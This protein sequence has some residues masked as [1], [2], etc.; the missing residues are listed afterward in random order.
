MNKKNLIGTWITIPDT[1]IAEILCSSNLDWITI[2]REHSS[3]SYEQ[4]EN[5]IRIA[6]LNKMK[7]YVRIS[8]INSSEI[9]K[10]LDSGADGIIIPN[11]KTEDQIEKIVNYSYYPPIGIR[12]VGLTR[13]NMFGEKF[14]QYYNN[15]S[16]KIKLIV[17]IEHYKAVDNI[18]K[19]LSN[20]YVDG[21]FIGPYDLSAS[22]GVPGKFKSKKYLKYENKIKTYMKNNELLKGV[23][24]IDPDINQ[25]NSKIKEGYNF[26][27]FS[28]D[29]KMIQNSLSNLTKIK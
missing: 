26:I 16:K 15:Y 23:H 19:I 25:V 7:V 12:G 17:Q 5:I 13:A 9:K 22:L 3:I 10:V 8:S 28:L 29:F 4:V 1:R 6:N 24:V 27:A 21:F 14:N 2:D 18:A 11:V 20:K